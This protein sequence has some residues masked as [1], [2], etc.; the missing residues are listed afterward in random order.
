MLLLTIRGRTRAEHLICCYC[1]V[2]VAEE[3]LVLMNLFNAETRA[4]LT[5]YFWLLYHYNSPR[6]KNKPQIIFSLPMIIPPK[7]SLIVTVEGFMV[8]S[9]FAPR[10][11]RI[12]SS[13]GFRQPNSIFMFKQ[14][15]TS[16]VSTLLK[17]D[18]K[19][20]F[21]GKHTY[22]RVAWGLGIK[23]RKEKQRQLSEALR[24][25][26]LKAVD[27]NLAADEARPGL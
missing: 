15:Q 6:G 10:M 14:R 24:R 12:I 23:K 19:Q 9:L 3:F 7:K 26:R 27:P 22:L 5:F 8:L 17:V 20:T 2:P 1:V 4:S 18:V 11:H 21:G 13:P 16:G 25:E